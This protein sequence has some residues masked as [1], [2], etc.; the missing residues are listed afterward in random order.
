MRADLVALGAA[1]IA[2]PT[3]PLFNAD[4]PTKLKRL[5]LTRAELRTR[6]LSDRFIDYLE[7]WSLVT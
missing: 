6:G 2:N 4:D 7:R 5:P 1:G 3:W